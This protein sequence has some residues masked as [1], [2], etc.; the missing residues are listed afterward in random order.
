MGRRIGKSE[1]TVSTG[2]E[3]WGAEEMGT[4]VRTQCESGDNGRAF[5]PYQPGGLKIC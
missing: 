5:N 2:G 1:S 3:P 4:K